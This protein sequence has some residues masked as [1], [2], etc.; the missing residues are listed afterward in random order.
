MNLNNTVLIPTNNV[1]Q[2]IQRNQDFYNH[3]NYSSS[4]TSYTRPSYNID[5]INP[6]L[7]HNLNYILSNIP[8]QSNFINPNLTYNTHH[9]NN[10]KSNL[11]FQ[12]S[13]YLRVNSYNAQRLDNNN[14]SKELNFLNEQLLDIVALAKNLL[15]K[16]CP[17]DK[18][19]EQFNAS[20]VW[21]QKLSKYL[22]ASN[23]SEFKK[24]QS[25]LKS[26]KNFIAKSLKIHIDYQIVVRNKEKLSY[27]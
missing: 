7:I 20:R 9:Q 6:E 2:L 1:A 19:I 8:I 18:N 13:S 17:T 5:N 27:S 12:Y 10:L 14:N 22:E 26:L 21:R 23:F 3:N 11:Q 4:Y 25:L 16:N 15:V 24:S